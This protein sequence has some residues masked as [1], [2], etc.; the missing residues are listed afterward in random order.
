MLNINYGALVVLLFDFLDSLDY[1][2]DIIK[3]FF[4]KDK[5]LYKNYFF[6]TRGPMT[7]NMEGGFILVTQALNCVLFFVR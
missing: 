4:I 1:L 3:Y 7:E 5:K 2:K 6:F